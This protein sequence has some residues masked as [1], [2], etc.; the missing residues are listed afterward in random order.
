MIE[1]VLAERRNVL[2]EMESK[3]LLAAFHIPVTRTLLA[4]SAPRR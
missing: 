4:R 1:S 2:T 3:T